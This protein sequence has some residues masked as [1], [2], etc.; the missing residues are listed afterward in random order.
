KIDGFHFG[1]MDIM[2]NNYEELEEDLFLFPLH[3]TIQMNLK[4]ETKRLLLRPLVLTDAEAMFA[5]DS[6]P[7]VHKYLWQK[8]STTIEETIKTIEY[9]QKQYKENNIGRFATILKETGE[10]IGWTASDNKDAKDFLANLRKAVLYGL[11]K[12]K[13]L[14]ALTEIPAKLLNQSNSIGSLNKGS[15]ANF[16]IVSGDLFD[17]KSTIQEN[18]IQGNRNII[19]KMNIE[20]I[21]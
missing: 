17:E 6:N 12:E 9:V 8:P 18:W 14:A 1:R 3:Q 10:F 21:R 4:L 5:M 20:D 16:I 11:P 15:L 13:A 2:F 7:N 19:D